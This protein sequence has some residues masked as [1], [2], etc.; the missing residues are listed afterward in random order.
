MKLSVVFLYNPYITCCRGRCN[1]RILKRPISKRIC[2]FPW[3]YKV[4]RDK[5]MII[6]VDQKVLL[7]HFK[8]SIISS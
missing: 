4:N 7:F 8:L 5:L 3:Q 1:N 6:I 2:I